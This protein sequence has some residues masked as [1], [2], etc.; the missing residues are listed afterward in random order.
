MKARI[1][2]EEQSRCFVA[3]DGPLVTHRGQTVAI[4]VVDD[5]EPEVVNALLKFVEQQ[6]A[7]HESK[8]EAAK[9]GDVIPF[10]GKR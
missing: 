1:W 2:K 3:S 6:L 8:V 7:A 9:S 10:R 4:F 5:Y